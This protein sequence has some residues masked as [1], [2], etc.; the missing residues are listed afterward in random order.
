LLGVG[1]FLREVD[2]GIEIA[3]E[4]SE[5]LVGGNLFFGALAVA[6]NG[7]RRLLIVPEIGLGNTGFERLQAFAVRSGVKDNSEP[8]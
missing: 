1:F 5:F 2:V 6:Q 8:C 3:G 4:R 7:L